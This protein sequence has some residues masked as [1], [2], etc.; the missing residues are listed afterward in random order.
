MLV[1]IVFMLVF[2]ISMLRKQK[3]ELKYCLVWIFSLLGIAVFVAFPQLLD[4]LSDLL[5]IA[6]PVFALFLI[7]IAFL[8][9]ICIGLTV[10][11]SRLSCRLNKLTQNIAIA[12]CELNQ[13]RDKTDEPSPCPVLRK[14]KS[15]E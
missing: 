12:E 7:C 2:F 5:G 15:D 13:S 10:V 11:V 9:C 3:L 8:A 1:V 4:M 14:E 6:T